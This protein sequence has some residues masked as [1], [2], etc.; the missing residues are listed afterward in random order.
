MCRD[1]APICPHGAT[2]GQLQPV[3][4]PQRFAWG[5]WERST[6]TLSKGTSSSCNTQRG[7]IERVGANSYNTIST[8]LANR[9]VY[10]PGDTVGIFQGCVAIA[11]EHICRRR[12]GSATSFDRAVKPCIH[13]I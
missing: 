4:A 1:P 8:S 12:R 13:I 7:R 10:P 3:V 9:S 11:P 6:L 2:T 5:P